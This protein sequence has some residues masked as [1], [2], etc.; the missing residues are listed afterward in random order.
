MELTTDELYEL[1]RQAYELGKSEARREFKDSPNDKYE[2]VPY[3]M[4]P[5]YK[6]PEFE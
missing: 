2:K 5:D 4:R 6:L 3:W 1:L